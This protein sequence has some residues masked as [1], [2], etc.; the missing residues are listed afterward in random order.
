MVLELRTITRAHTSHH[1]RLGDDAL[2][3][4][5]GSLRSARIARYANLALSTATLPSLFLSLRKKT[6]ETSG[7]AREGAL[8]TMGK[9][10]MD[11]TSGPTLQRLKHSQG[12]FTE[13][14]R[15][16]SNRKITFLDDALGRAW[17][18]RNISG[19]EYAALRKY[20][21]HWLAGGLM[22]HL[23]SVDLNRVL[24][25]DPGAMSG[26]AKTEKQADHRHLYHSARD[27]IGT[28]P[29]LV[30]DHIAC[31]DSTL[32]H[33]GAVLGYRS[34]PRGRSKAIEILSDAG[35]RLAQFWDEIARNH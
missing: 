33:V 20:S 12:F 9:T 6:V 10:Q 27:N 11:D 15:S 18:R 34:G 26:L 16:R 28:R 32:S 8:L 22:G 1:G 31:F 13:A 29:A 24:A 17:M 14:G 2:W 35:Y 19:E 3:L 25:F 4:S 21:L 5:L 23:G 30:A 7:Y